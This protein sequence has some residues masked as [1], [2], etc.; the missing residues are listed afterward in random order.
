MNKHDNLHT[1]FSVLNGCL[2]YAYNMTLRD[3][4]TTIVLT[5]EG[6]DDIMFICPDEYH[7]DDFVA[8][9]SYDSS[10]EIRDGE[11]DTILWTSEDGQIP[12]SNILSGIRYYL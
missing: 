9:I 6:T 3:N 7:E 8:Y 4:E 5:R 12:L 11:Y 2:S 10:G 1:L